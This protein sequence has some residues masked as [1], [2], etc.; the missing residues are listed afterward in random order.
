MPDTILDEIIKYKKADVE[1]LKSY[2]TIDRHKAKIATMNAPRDFAWALREDGS[3]KIR[4]IAEVKKASPSKGVMREHFMPYEMA[5][6]YQIGG[7]SAISV[8]TEEKHFLGK[9]D[10][11]VSIKIY[12][13][14]PI[15]RKDF[16]FD[17]YQIYESRAS[18]ADAIL[19]IA[20]ILEKQQLAD[21]MGRATELGMYTLVE[22]HNEEEM[23][24][25]LDVDAK[26]IGV[27]NRGLKT[28]KTDIETTIRL[29]P[30]VP[31]DKILVSESGIS[32]FDDI[33]RLRKNGVNAFLIGEALIKERELAKKL[34]ELRG[35]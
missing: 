19:L 29:A 7:A 2:I 22:V 20:A 27:N 21:L 16:I 10:Y 12:T 30:Y 4:I 26:I 31:E 15:L 1:K 6:E 11:L 9:L 3:G 23:E 8:L 35:A 13:R 32:S 18:G 33:V 34:R 28:M 5:R 24:A 17:D 14:L 25:A